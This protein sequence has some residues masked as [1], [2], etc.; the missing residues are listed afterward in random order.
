VQ[1][2]TFAR[3][4]VVSSTYRPLLVVP[5]G[6]LVKRAQGRSFGLWQLGA[7][8]VPSARGLAQSLEVAQRLLKFLFAAALETKRKT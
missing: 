6:S 1:Q 8:R 3:S 2:E 5:N 4:W 7:H